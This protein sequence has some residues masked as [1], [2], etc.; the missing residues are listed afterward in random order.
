MQDTK[1]LYAELKPAMEAI[2][3]P[4][5]DFSKQCLR[6]RGNFLPHAAVLT[7]AGKL[8]LVAAQPERDLT[9]ATEVL[10][11][12]QGSLRALVKEK[13][14]SAVA[15]AEN[16][17]ITIPG[18]SATDAIKVLF[19]HQR[20]LTVALYVPFSKNFLRGYVFG[21]MISM[22]APPEVNAW[23]SSGTT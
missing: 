9:N 7:G 19:E 10:P 20:G 8:A 15:I 18:Q 21:D 12:L 3:I 17:N 6:D 2:A 11:L 23:S 1:S 22:L 16:V 13:G 4:L 14:H 5:F